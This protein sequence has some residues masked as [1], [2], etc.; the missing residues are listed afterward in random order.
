MTDEERRVITA[1]VERIAGVQQGQQPG[2]GGGS[3]PQARQPLPPVDPEADR[4]LR[5]LFNRH[6]EARYRITQTAFE[7]SAAN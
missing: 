4:M 2:W 5:E 6:T 3:V 1:F 7:K